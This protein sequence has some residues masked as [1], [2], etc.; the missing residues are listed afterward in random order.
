MHLGS[1]ARRQSCPRIG[2]KRTTVLMFFGQGLLKSK[3]N[4]AAGFLFHYRQK[5]NS[6]TFVSF[7]YYL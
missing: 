3:Q 4:S 6:Y 5:M 2:S 1:L 7:G